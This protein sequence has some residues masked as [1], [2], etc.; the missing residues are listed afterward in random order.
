MLLSLFRSSSVICISVFISRSCSASRPVCDGTIYG[1]PNSRDCSSAWHSMPFALEP[2]D[3]YNAK[4]FEL[5]SEPQYLLP[6]FAGVTNRY[7]PL[8]INQLPK[9]WRYSTFTSLFQL[10]FLPENPPSLLL[11]QSTNERLFRHMPC[12]THELRST[13]SLC[14]ERTLGLKLE[15]DLR[16]DAET[17]RV[18]QPPKRD[19]SKWRIHGSYPY[20]GPVRFPDAVYTSGADPADG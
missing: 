6:A 7:K 5:Y 15:M 3:S 10:N 16:S 9:I 20:V 12:C 19:R 17:F 13:E 2:R 14:A 4:R 18:R 11:L 8:P 1:V